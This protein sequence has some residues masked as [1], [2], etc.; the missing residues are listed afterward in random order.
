MSAC[1]K[2]GI[3]GSVLLR[4][5][6]LYC[7]DCFIVNINHKFRASIGKNKILSRNEKVLICSSG[8]PGSTALMDFVHNG[9][10]LENH[11]KMWIT[12]IVLHIMGENV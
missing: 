12:P 1:K 4:K 9:I 3:K 8:G 11:K 6:D 10:S 2:C 5:K 7:T